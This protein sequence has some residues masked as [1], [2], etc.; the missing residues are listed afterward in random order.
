MPIS[1]DGAGVITGITLL[2]PETLTLRQLTIT[3]SASMAVDNRYQFF[4]ITATNSTAFTI[5][6]PLY[7]I[8]DGQTITF[9]I[10]NT[11]GGALGTATWGALYKLATWTQPATGFNRSITF[12]FNGTNFVELSRT[13]AD[14][15]N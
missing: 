4:V 11:S 7:P 10:K 13:A 9:T 12:T 2:S 5:A 3:Y 8:L 14:V 1:I 15:P 6:N